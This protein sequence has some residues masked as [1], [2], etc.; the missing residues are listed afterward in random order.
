M[1]RRYLPGY[2]FPQANE[3]KEER[4]MKTL[5]HMKESNI[6]GAGFGVFATQ[7]IPKGL[8]LGPYRGMILSKEQ[9]DTL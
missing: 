4:L 8:N 2:I 6:P 3:T 1:T 7:R 5:V 9:M